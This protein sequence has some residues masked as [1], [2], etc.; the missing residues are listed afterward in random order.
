MNSNSRRRSASKRLTGGTVA[1]LLLLSSTAWAGYVPPSQPSAPRGG[2]T[3]TTGRRGGCEGDQSSSL[4]V[5]APVSHIGQT[6]SGH[7]TFAWYAPNLP[8]IPI[9]FFL[10]SER[11]SILY[12]QQLDS[13]PGIM[14]LTLPENLPALQ[15]GESYRWQVVLLCNPNRPSSAIVAQAEL[16]VVPLPPGLERSLPSLP[17]AAVRSSQLAEAGLWYDAFALAMQNP[18]LQT[19]RRELLLSLAQIENSQGQRD[20]SSQLQQIAD[21]IL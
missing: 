10:F 19:A 21:R 14:S 4:T 9:E 3:T 6:T 16:R 5:L 7:P 15:A 17:N 8:G 18:R 20:R 12:R 1:F 13:V 2:N 11:G